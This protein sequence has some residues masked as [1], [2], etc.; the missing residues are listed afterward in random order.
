MTYSEFKTKITSRLLWGNCLG[1]I[2]TNVLL[3][4]AVFVF[5]GYY[6]HHGE[7]ISVPDLRGMA[8][9]SA[10]AKLHS[11]GLELEVADTGYVRTLPP[12]VILG[13]QV[14]PGSEVKVGRVIRVTINSAN[15]PTI[16]LPDLADN[17]SYHEAK[18]RL[19]AIGFRLAAV[20]YTT[21][22][23]DWVYAIK[24]HGRTVTAGQKIPVNS[25]VTIV[26]GD[27]SVNDEFNGDDDMEEAIFGYA[28]D[29]IG[30]Y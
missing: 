22:E 27:G 7:N 23:H 14:T 2:I 24:V 4:A 12:D 25:P 1:M 5:L 11:L 10:S 30:N 13:Q 20:E 3:I 6:T 8:E 15:S 9:A 16:T 18:A 26:V 21:G 17:C 19:T 28:H 29:S